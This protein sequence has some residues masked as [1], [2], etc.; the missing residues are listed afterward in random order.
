MIVCICRSLNETAVRDAVTAGARDP[1]AVQAH[2]GCEF[3]CGRCRPMIG[4]IISDEV[5]AAVSPGNLVAAE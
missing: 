1:D 5:D 2:H 4:D 3:N